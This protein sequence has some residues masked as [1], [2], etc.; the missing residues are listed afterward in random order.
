MRYLKGTTEILEISVARLRP[1]ED[2]IPEWVFTTDGDEIPGATR[3]RIYGCARIREVYQHLK[4]QYDGRFTIP[5]LVDTKQNKIV[6]NA[7]TPASALCHANRVTG[8]R[9]DDAELFDR[10]QY[11][12]TI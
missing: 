6:N 4:P 9:R 7:G 2:G 1:K 3:D 12:S 11:H 10:I 5:L 8:E